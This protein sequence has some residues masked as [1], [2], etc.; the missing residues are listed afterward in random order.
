[1]II[2]W[3]SSFARPRLWRGAPKPAATIKK[4]D[5]VPKCCDDKKFNNIKLS[6]ISSGK[7]L[8]SKKYYNKMECI[9]LVMQNIEYLP[10]SRLVIQNGM[11]VVRQST[12][13]LQWQKS[14]SVIASEC[15]ERGNLIPTSVIA[16][17][18]NERGNLIPTSVI[19]SE[20]NERGNLILIIIIPN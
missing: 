19:A 14:L 1:M 3:I 5:V 9:T 13:Y 2:I 18:C 16:S 7:P 15:N 17:E 6:V 12:N 8:H 10:A 4:L 11:Q 20:C